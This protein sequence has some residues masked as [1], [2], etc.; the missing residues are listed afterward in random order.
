MISNN[1][2]Y[3]YTF[4]HYYQS[5]Y[6]NIISH[7][8]NNRFLYIIFLLYIDMLFFYV[9]FLYIILVDIYRTDMM[10]IYNI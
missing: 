5:Y 2:T 8:G 9:I 4:I 3:L 10:H 6:I 1:K 7:S